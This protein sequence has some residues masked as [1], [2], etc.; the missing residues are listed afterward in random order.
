MH[1]SSRDHFAQHCNYFNSL[2]P[3]NRFWPLAD[4][5][6]AWGQ[7]VP[8]SVRAW[9]RIGFLIVWDKD[10]LSLIVWRIC[11]RSRG[12]SGR[13]LQV[14]KAICFHL[15][16]VFHL[17][18]VIEEPAG[19]ALRSRIVGMRFKWGPNRIESNRFE[20]PWR[21]GQV[22]NF[23]WSCS[24]FVFSSHSPELTEHYNNHNCEP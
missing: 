13:C 9:L 5:A 18:I 24:G 8:P 4:P 6:L 10:K 14:I 11:C 12:G 3:A 19:V 15:S 22:E 7:S 16:R 2:C 20:S 23:N 1:G 17:S 21:C